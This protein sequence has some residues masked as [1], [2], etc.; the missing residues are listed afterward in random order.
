M[1][2]KIEGGQIKTDLFKKKTDRAQY[3]LPTSCHPRHI[4]DSI[5]YSLALRLVRICSD[6]ESLEKRMGEL[7]VLLKQRGYRHKKIHAAFSRALAI[8]REEALQTVQKEP[9]TRITFTVTY[10]PQLLG[11]PGVFQKHWRAMT[12]DKRMLIIFE[13]P[14]MIS[15]RQPPNLKRLLCKARLPGLP[16]I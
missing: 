9:L 12:R 7:E 8:S 3:L 16:Y 15:F 14:P 10:N 6:E 2:L 5:P 13:E 4:C 1:S 11:L